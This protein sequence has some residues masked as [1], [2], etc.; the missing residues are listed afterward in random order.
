M[1]A[2]T[3]PAK[4]RSDSKGKKHTCA[5]ILCAMKRKTVFVLFVVPEV[6]SVAIKRQETLTRGVFYRVPKSKVIR[7]A[8]VR[9]P[10]LFPRRWE[11]NSH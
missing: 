5:R 4:A 7:T 11:C 10:R 1:V 8:C 9:A 3:S 2:G 6:G